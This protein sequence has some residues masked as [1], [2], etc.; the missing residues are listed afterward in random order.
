MVQSRSLLRRVILL[1]LSKKP[2]TVKRLASARRAPIVLFFLL[3]NARARS[4]SCS[5]S[6]CPTVDQ[7]AQAH[8]GAACAFSSAPRRTSRSPPW[9]TVALAWSAIIL[10]PA[11]RT[12]ATFCS[13]F[14]L[15]L[16]PA[17]VPAAVWPPSRASAPF[18]ATVL[19]ASLVACYRVFFRVA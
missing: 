9:R 4:S 11:A 16:A 19:V 2:I 3:S 13:R 18:P 14:R 6:S 1:G 12:A 7:H 5:S 17:A 8:H 15:D 10:V